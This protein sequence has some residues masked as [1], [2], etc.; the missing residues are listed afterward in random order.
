MEEIREPVE[1]IDE[2]LDVVAGGATSASGAGL[3]TAST[4]VN[5]SFT[6]GRTFAAITFSGV[7]PNSSSA[8]A[9]G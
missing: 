2:D 5:N 4:S 6:E 9:A 3:Y 8:A 7:G 1:L